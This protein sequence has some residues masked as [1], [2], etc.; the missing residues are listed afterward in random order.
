MPTKPS[1]IQQE[2]Q[3]ETVTGHHG[4]PQQTENAASVSSNTDRQP[5]KKL[6][7]T[8]SGGKRSKEKARVPRET[9]P[10]IQVYDANIDPNVA[11]PEDQQAPLQDTAVQPIDEQSWQ[12]QHQQPDTIQPLEENRWQQQNEAQVDEQRWQ[13]Q[14]NAIQP[15]DERQWQQQNEAQLDEHHWQEQ[16]V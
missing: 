11:L 16:R 6:S 5:T 14:Q 7:R 13:E 1:H 4:N 3:A 12:H 8:K 2:I 10:S 9:G 15:V